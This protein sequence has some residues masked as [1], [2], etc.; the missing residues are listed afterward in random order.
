MIWYN[1]LIPFTDRIYDMTHDINLS[2]DVDISAVQTCL[3]SGVSMPQASIVCCTV[4]CSSMLSKYMG[5]EHRVQ[6]EVPPAC[7]P[8]GALVEYLQHNNS[9][10]LHDTLSDD[11]RQQ[12]G[13]CLC[14][15]CLIEQLLS[16]THDALGSK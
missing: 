9:T 11:L 4:F 5:T 12:S 14:G 10:Y 6:A 16:P 3:K 13:V 8:T 1:I 15:S 2:R 7:V